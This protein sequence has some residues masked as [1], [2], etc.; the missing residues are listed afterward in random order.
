MGLFALESL[1]NF[2]I[3]RLNFICLSKC[4]NSFLSIFGQ[5]LTFKFQKDVKKSRFR[6][7]GQRC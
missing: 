7:T 3:G 4:Q 5:S 1:L 6:F 2:H